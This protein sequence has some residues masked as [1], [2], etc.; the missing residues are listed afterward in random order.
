MDK[1]YRVVYIWENGAFVSDQHVDF[2][3]AYK[4]LVDQYGQPT[5]TEIRSAEDWS[6]Q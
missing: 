5:K 3:E 6:K 4:E 2:P 1:N